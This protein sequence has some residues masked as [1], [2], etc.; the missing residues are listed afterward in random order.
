MDSKLL[1]WER[2]SRTLPPHEREAFMELVTHMKNRRSAIDAAD[3]PDIGIA[4]L[5]AAIVHLKL[6]QGGGADDSHRNTIA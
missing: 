5:L 3:E 1:Q 2:F 4:M 6:R